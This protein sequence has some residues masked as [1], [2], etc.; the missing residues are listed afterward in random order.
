MEDHNHK[1]SRR[2]IDGLVEMITE[3]K[4]TIKKEEGK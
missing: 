1:K 2:R 3:Q 4:K